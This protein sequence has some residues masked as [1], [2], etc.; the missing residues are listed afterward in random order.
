MDTAKKTL[1][2]PG[3]G[4]SARFW[5][6]VADRLGMESVLLSW[7]GLGNEPTRQDVNGTDDLIALVLE[8][9]DSPVNLV[10]QSMGGFIALK[11]ALAAPQYV[12]RLV[13]T[14]T[15]GGI[16]VADLGGSC[17]R[18]DY[19]QAFPGAAGWIA[20]PVEDLSGQLQSIAA[21]TLLLWGDSDP[22]SPVPVGEHLQTL[23]PNAN[24]QVIA[25][26]DHDLAHLHADLV[27]KLIRQHLTAAF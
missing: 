22:I 24:L 8:H 26:G 14:A 10:A 19:F 18:E 9:L 12:R 27:A 2:L 11:V 25:G 17:W 20:D 3:A 6:P 4:A 1:F 5:Q 16:P 7:P 15:S 13:L 21:P 23:L